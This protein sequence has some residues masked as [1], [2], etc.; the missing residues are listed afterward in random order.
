[1]NSV[2]SQWDP[3]ELRR[4]RHT[5][6]ALERL[7]AMQPGFHHGRAAELVR[8]A[9][10]TDSVIAGRLARLQA[11]RAR[12]QRTAGIMAV[13]GAL[14]AVLLI[15]LVSLAKLPIADQIILIVSA[16]INVLMFKLLVFPGRPALGAQMLLQLVLTMV[17]IVG[18]GPDPFGAGVALLGWAATL[19]RE[20]LERRVGALDISEM[21]LALKVQGVDISRAEMRLREAAQI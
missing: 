21:E 6:A 16:G 17:L 15:L 1:M 12:L 10:E 13:G 5:R 20:W 2:A 4:Q 3:S 11:D 19:G 14:T 7:M 8:A 18:L 9:A